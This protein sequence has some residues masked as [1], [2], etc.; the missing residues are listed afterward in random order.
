[1][2]PPRKSSFRQSL[3][4]EDNGI[5]VQRTFCA[6]EGTLTR[7]SSP[8]HTESQT[9][10]ILQVWIPTE[11]QRQHTLPS[12][13]AESNHASFFSRQLPRHWSGTSAESYRRLL[14]LLDRAH[15]LT[16]PAAL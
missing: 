13:Q 16:S 1:M 9:L 12:L 8:P 10:S 3:L 6:A 7:D 14:H 2:L 15:G 5:C 4:D 11:R